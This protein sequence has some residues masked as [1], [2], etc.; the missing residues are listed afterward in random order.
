MREIQ[1]GLVVFGAFDYGIDD[2]G[3]AAL[4][5]L[6]ANEI[7]HLVGAL[8]GDAARDDR[9]AARRQLVE[10]ADVEVA[11]E[12]KRECA[13][14][15][16][17][18]HHQHVGLRLVG[19]LHQPE[20]LQHAEAVLL[21]DDDEAET[22]ELDFLFN[23]R[24]G[25]DDQLRLAAID[26]AAVGALAVFV[27]RAGEQ[28]DAIAARGALKQLARGEKM[29]RGQDLSG[30]HERGL[31]AVFHGDEHGLQGDDGFAG[32]HVA[33]QQA[34][35]GTGLAH[36]GDDFAQGALLRRRGME[37]QHLADG[38][39]DLV[40]GGE[41]DAGALAHAAALEF[42][43]QFEKE[44]LFKDEAAMSGCGRTPAAA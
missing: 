12:R 31:V 7:P 34:A 22:V 24:M 41:A 36:V 43:A 14:N 30:R 27:E 21:V 35:H 42:E 10:H 20:A 33:L 26:E 23:Q 38:F 1:L 9:R 19:L 15:G 8:A 28:H 6:L 4:R 25:A 2:V 17:R 32:A 18:G 44:Q 3:L 16:R 29:L 39:A 37:G 13:R 40:G 5:H 11:V